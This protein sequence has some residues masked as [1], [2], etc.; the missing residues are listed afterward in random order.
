MQIVGLK[1]L[2]VV[3]LYVFLFVTDENVSK[4]S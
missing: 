4:L 1:L 2:L 3:L